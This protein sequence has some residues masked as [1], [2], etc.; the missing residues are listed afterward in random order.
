[1]KIKNLPFAV[2]KKERE[3]YDKRFKDLFPGKYYNKFD[4]S[5]C[6]E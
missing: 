5:K 4:P 6:M 3:E 1:M 2:T